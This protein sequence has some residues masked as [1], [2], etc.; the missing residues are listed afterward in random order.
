M[1]LTEMGQPVAYD[2]PLPLVLKN[3]G[4]KVKIFDREIREPPHLTIIR[5]TTRW[6]LNLRTRTFMDARPPPSEVPA[7]LLQIIEGQWTVL[8]QQWDAMYP[9]N[10]VADQEG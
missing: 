6:R 3:A 9:Q 2:L 1:A 5:K 8:C 7:A 10:P 4:W